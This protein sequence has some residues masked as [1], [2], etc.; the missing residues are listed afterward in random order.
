ML[1]P[2][3]SVN[4]RL[5]SGPVVIP[6][7]WLRAVGM[8]NSAMAWVVGLISLILLA[9]PV[10][11]VNQMLPSGPAV[12]WKGALLA[13]GIGNSLMVTDNSRRDS[14][15]ST[16]SRRLRLWDPPETRRKRRCLSQP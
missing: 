8:G 11:S 16:W 9:V 3:P 5:P 2:N 15:P 13:V 4:Q 7:G 1:L 14:R 6:V 10:S 12:I